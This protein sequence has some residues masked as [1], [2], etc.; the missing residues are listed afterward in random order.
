[1]HLK[2]LA[3]GTLLAL[4]TIAMGS[5][6]AYHG[7]DQDQLVEGG[8]L[9]VD[10]TGNVYVGKYS[11]EPASN[12]EQIEDAIE[13]QPFYGYHQ[14]AEKHVQH[15]K[16]ETPK[17]LGHLKQP[18]TPEQHEQLEQSPT[19]EQQKPLEQPEMPTVHGPP[20]HPVQLEQPQQ[21][22][23]DVLVIEQVNTR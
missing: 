14:P 2:S 13:L 16:S 12:S 9:R 15:E 21:P 18:E 19:A 4:S 23:K 3:R 11:Q 17:Q 5:M 20:E 10:N 6:A 22:V 7:S 8:I 1:M